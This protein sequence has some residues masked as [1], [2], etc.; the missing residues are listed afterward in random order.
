MAV[1]EQSESEPVGTDG[2][3]VEKGRVEASLPPLTEKVHALS[4]EYAESDPTVTDGTDI[5]E[6]RTS[7]PAPTE[8]EVQ[9]SEFT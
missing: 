4:R 9:P 8:K 3:D 2:T 5:E 6:A 1:Q 7:R